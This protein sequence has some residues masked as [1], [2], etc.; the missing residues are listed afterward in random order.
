MFELSITLQQ[1][2]LSLPLPLTLFLSS[3]SILLHLLCSPLLY[4]NVQ[5][6]EEMKM[7]DMDC[8]QDGVCA[9]DLQPLTT[10][11]RLGCSKALGHLW[12]LEIYRS[13]VVH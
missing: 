2:H 12:D 11:G 8:T 13:T 3:F 7:C 4:Q 1:K 10:A 5:T 6:G 9:L